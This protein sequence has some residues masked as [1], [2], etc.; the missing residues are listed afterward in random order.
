[1]TNRLNTLSESARWR[2]LVDAAKQGAQEQGYVLSR[3]P[4]R[5]LSNVWNME[6]DGKSQV[7]AIRTTRDLW[8]AFPPLEGGTKWKTLDDAELVV[9][10]SVDSKDDPQNIEI[11][12]FPAQEVRK[13]FNA[14]YA[15]RMKAGHV[16]KDNYGMWVALHPDE[17]GIASSVGSGIAKQYPA[18]AIYSI[19]ALMAAKPDETLQGGEEQPEPGEEVEPEFPRLTTIAD[20]MAWARERVAEI[21]GVRVE[22]VKLDLKMEY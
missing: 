9:V 3:I 14:A 20:V 7:G 12:I 22:A 13:R 1:M 4:G 16:Q 21:A 8:I 5:G 2:L 10:A 17:R 19:E 6:K 18:V 15:A 11:Y